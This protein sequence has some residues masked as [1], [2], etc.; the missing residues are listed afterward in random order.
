MRL[1]LVFRNVNNVRCPRHL[2]GY[3]NFSSELRG[4]ADYDTAGKSICLKRNLPWANLHSS[5][6]QE[7]KWNNLLKELR[8]SDLSLN[9]LKLKLSNFY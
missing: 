7:K 1:Q 9:T 2:Q 4:M 8:V 3:I 5:M 6:L